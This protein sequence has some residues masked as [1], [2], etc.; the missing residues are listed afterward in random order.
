MICVIKS[1]SGFYKII[2][3]KRKYD[4]VALIFTLGQIT[5]TLAL[6]TV[7]STHFCTGWRKWAKK[8]YNPKHFKAHSCFIVVVSF[9]RFV[10]ELTR[11][12]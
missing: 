1:Q 12:I 11:A 5:F 8:E 10:F 7:Y 4:F 2:K 9:F 6:Y 3:K